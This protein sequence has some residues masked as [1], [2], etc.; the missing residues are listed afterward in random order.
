MKR[1]IFTLMLALAVAMFS[2]S[3]LAAEEEP[4]ALPDIIEKEAWIVFIVEPAG[5]F[6]DARKEFLN[7]DL[8]AA[9]QDILAGTVIIKVETHRAKGEEKEALKASIRELKKLAKAVEK[10]AV[11]SGGILEEAFARAEIALAQHHYQ[12]ALHYEANEDYEKMAY[13]VDAAARH[14]LYASF[15]ADDDLEEDEVVAIKEGRSLVRKLIRGATWGPKKMGQAVKSIARGIQ[16]LS[17]K[18]KPLKGSL[19]NRARRNP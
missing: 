6:Q 14:L 10:G 16:S 13:A 11:A 2:P 12:K 5:Y 8:H 3:A 9:A 18:I 7:G 17:K 19:R 1:I 15:W 4:E